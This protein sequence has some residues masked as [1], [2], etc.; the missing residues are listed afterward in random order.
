MLPQTLPR[1][2]T[3]EDTYYDKIDKIESIDMSKLFKNIKPVSEDVDTISIGKS[4]LDNSP[5]L[6]SILK[7]IEKL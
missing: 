4:I 2:N 6:A 1:A 5:Q 7:N 3:Q